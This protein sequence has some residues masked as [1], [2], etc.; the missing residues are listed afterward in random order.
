LRQRERTRLSSEFLSVFLQSA[1]DYG[2]KSKLTLENQVVARGLIADEEVFDVDNASDEIIRGHLNIEIDNELDLQ[3]IFD[4]FIRKNLEPF[5]PEER[6]V[7]RLKEAIYGFFAVSFVLEYA[8]DQVQIIN[9]ALSKANVQ[10]FVNVIDDSKARYLELVS[11]RE[12][13]LV[14]VENWNVPETIN[15]TGDEVGH[16]VAQSVML[17]FY[18][19]TK[20]KTELAFIALLE[21]SDK[22]KWWFKNGER[23]ATYFAIPYVENGEQKPFYVDFVVQLE[24]GR[25]ALFDTKR[26]QTV[27]TSK[28]KSDGL[29]EYISQDSNLFG[30]IVDNTKEDFTGRWMYFAG[31]S[32]ALQEGD[33]S[34]WTLLDI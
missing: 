34:N 6:S 21:K 23:D 22:V 8:S 9:S 11:T 16:Q 26:G 20:F 12:K 5:H 3:K 29:Q 28:E 10:H 17:P 14:V 2:L 19:S 15:Y 13:E 7:G 31:G 24:D 33:F 18:S 27:K 25:I 32:S 1:L 30:G 4:S